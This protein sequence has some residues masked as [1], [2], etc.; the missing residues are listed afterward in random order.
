[1]KQRL[2]KF[3]VLSAALVSLGAADAALAQKQGGTLR[4]Y[5][6]DSPASMS[7]HEEGTVGVM[8]PMMGVFN[9]L[10]LFDQ[11]IPQNSLESI[12]PE[13]AMSWAWSEDGTELTFKLREGV[14]WHDGKPFTAEDV[15]CTFDLLTNQG[16]EKFRL[17]YRE[18]WWVN[19]AR[20]TT[21][22]DQE[23][24]LHLKRP[25]PALLALLAAGDTPIYPCHVSPRDMRQHPI[26]TGPFKFVEYK[27][28]QNIKLA[29]NPDYWKPGRPYLD[30]VEYTIIPNRSTAILAFIAGKFDMT[31]PYEVTIPLL[32][33]IQTQLPQ[34]TCE[35]G[36][37]SES[38]G[39]LVNRTVAPFDNTE[40]RRAMALTLDRKSF[41]DILGQGEGEIGGALM[42]PPQGVWGMPQEMVQTLPGYGG[43]VQKN[44]EEAR[45][46][47]QKLG[48]GPDKRLPV[49]ISTRNLAVYRDPAAILID[50]LKEIYVDGELETIETANWVPKLMRKDFKVGL[51]VLGTAVDDPDVYFY[52]NYVCNSA[53]NY[54]GY[55]DQNFD[56]MVDQ[57]SMEADPAKRKKLVWD[58]DHKLQ[59]DMA[60]PIIY[61]LRAAT[62][63]QPE[64]KGLTMMTNS[65][66]NGWRFE[67]VWL[68]R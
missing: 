26:G 29:R 61:H 1:M 45:A 43:D 11:H 41:I 34:A 39:V 33:D 10:V 13:L 15:K 52:Q 38:I 25:Q 55:C 42:P 31:F 40:L 44:R 65:Q 58:I 16:K 23:A 56:K 28:N 7:I 50:Q 17:N 57:Q 53:R 5:H 12:V 18:T 24:T 60:R 68:D 27:P 20:T 30:G 37:A 51:N 21:R 19:V 47:M 46:I 62:C 64:V 67:D 49:K 48:Y 14:K 35:V 54:M 9:N 2:Q 4:V 63:W 22:G 36:L 8:M 66:Y 59:E 3:A 32:K 6:R